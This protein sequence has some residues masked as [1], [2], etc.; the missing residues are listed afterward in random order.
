[1]TDRE[2]AAYAFSKLLEELELEY[3]SD[4]SQLR[5]VVPTASGHGI[6]VEFVEIEVEDPVVSCAVLILP[7]LRGI[8]PPTT[9][10]IRLALHETMNML[11]GKLVLDDANGTLEVRHEVPLVD[12]AAGELSVILGALSTHSAASE[13]LELVFGG[14]PGPMY[15]DLLA[16]A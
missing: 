13:R 15:E 8:D 14:Q 1:M 6:A 4:T 10:A 7:L 11:I 12:L 16:G 9:D 5:F 3:A 2:E